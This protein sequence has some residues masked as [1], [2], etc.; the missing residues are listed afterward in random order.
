M[1]EV[2]DVILKL[3][4]YVFN[5]IESIN[6]KVAILENQ[7]KEAINDNGEPMDDYDKEDWEDEINK[8]QRERAQVE[9]LLNLIEDIIN[10]QSEIE[11]TQNELQDDGININET[12]YNI[13]DLIHIVKRDFIEN[14]SP[15]TLIKVTVGDYD[16]P[17]MET[18]FEYENS[19]LINENIQVPLNRSFYRMI[20][21]IDTD[22][23]NKNILMITSNNSV[24]GW[25]R[26]I[27]R[28]ILDDEGQVLGAYEELD[29]HYNQIGGLHHLVSNKLIKRRIITNQGNLELKTIVNKN[30]DDIYERTDFINDNKILNISFDEMDRF[31]DEEVEK[32]FSLLN[33][34]V[35]LAELDEVPDEMKEVLKKESIE[36]SAEQI[37]NKVPEMF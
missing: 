35:Q 28:P 32:H 37:K 24:S 14:D 9:E 27:K 11:V 18:E 36:K 16:I 10:R 4:E 15:N 33:S 19:E 29:N 22:D 21:I 23:E 2:L 7:L 20:K 1:I 8:L 17:S 30:G 13:T 34:Q 3:K 26:D 31:N 5:Q 6:D 12:V 25:T